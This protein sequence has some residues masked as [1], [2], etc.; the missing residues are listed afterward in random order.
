MGR[1]CSQLPTNQVIYSNSLLW[2]RVSELSSDHYCELWSRRLKIYDSNRNKI[3]FC[4]RVIVNKVYFFWVCFLFQHTGI[5]IY[6]WQ[7]WPDQHWLNQTHRLTRYFN[8][9]GLL[10]EKKV[11][12]F[13]SPC[14]ISSQEWSQQWQ[15]SAVQRSYYAISIQK[16]TWIPQERLFSW[17]SHLVPLSSWALKSWIKVPSG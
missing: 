15:K 6:Q 17:A 16:A 12:I 1:Q 9:W 4:S 14:S 5:F 11:F 7:I 13:V 3:H 2:T 10:E 8:D